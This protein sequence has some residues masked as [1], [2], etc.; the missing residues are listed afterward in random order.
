MSLT[1]GQKRAI[2]AAARQAGIDPRKNEDTYR[3]V[4]RNVGG[5]HSAAAKRASREGFIAVM[6]FL[7][8]RAGGQLKGNTPGYWAG[9]DATANPRDPIIY[10]IR[11]TAS[12][13]G[14]SN[15]QIDAFLAGPH[16]SS[17]RY[18]SLADAPTRWCVKVLEG[19]KQILARRDR[20]NR[21]ELF[22]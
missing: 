2:H 15:E 10:R 11:Q 4:L 14:L 8:E 5:F 13:L 20:K 6:A 12:K 17:G 22:I 3:L 16:C 18:E 9:Q 21:E 1:N 7:E 19:L